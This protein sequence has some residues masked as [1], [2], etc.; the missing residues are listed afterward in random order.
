MLRIRKHVLPLAVYVTLTS[1]FS[2]FLA[3]GRAWSGLKMAITDVKVLIFMIMT[4]A[5]L[6][7]LSFVN[8]FP[9]CVFLVGYTA[10]TDAVLMFCFLWHFRIRTGS[11]RP[12]DFRRRSVCS[13]PRTS[14]QF[15][16]PC[17]ASDF[18]LVLNFYTRQSPMDLCI[19]R[20]SR[21]CIARG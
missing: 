5:Q 14:C 7:G 8:F 16:V 4:C 2:F 20:V 21:E 1:H 19:D 11:L 6:L 9:T 17:G 10:V 13:W 3:A 12:L 18:V 15:F